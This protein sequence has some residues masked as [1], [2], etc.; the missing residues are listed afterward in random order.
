MLRSVNLYLMFFWLSLG[1]AILL[2]D[3]WLPANLEGSLFADAERMRLLGILAI[4]LAVWNFMRWYMNWSARRT[5]AMEQRLREDRER[6]NR[7]RKNAEP[8]VTDPQLRFGESGPESTL[9]LPPQSP[10]TAN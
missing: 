7:D 4:G 1:I 9:P 3:Y 8:I 6:A 2:R 5:Q 10:P